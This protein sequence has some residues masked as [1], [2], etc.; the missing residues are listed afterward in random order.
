M[1]QKIIN[2][3]IQ[4]MENMGI[5]TEDII[6]ATNERASR[7]PM[8]LLCEVDGV[9]KR[10]PFEEGKSK[11]IVGIFPF[12][13]DIF[14]HVEE[15]E[16]TVRTDV[17][18][19]KIPTCDIFDELHKIRVELN[20][21]LSSLGLPIVDGFYFAEPIITMHQPSWIVGWNKEGKFCSD[22]YDTNVQA[23]VR[24]CDIFE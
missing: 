5:T 6:I 3:I 17:D 21:A 13:N 15:R 11:K 7:K 24:Y 2:Q 9:K 19:T 20:E 16:E 8:D 23:K 18:E 12:A 10:L 14:L 1:K 22:Y 4:L